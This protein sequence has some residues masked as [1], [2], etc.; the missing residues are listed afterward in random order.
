MHLYSWPDWPD[1][2]HMGREAGTHPYGPS[3]SLAYQNIV[4]AVLLAA[5]NG[6]LLLLLLFLLLL[7][8]PLRVAIARAL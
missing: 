3:L 1:H 8:L 4:S 5:D 7:L 6:A 2:L